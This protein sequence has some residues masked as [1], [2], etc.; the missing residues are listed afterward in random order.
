VV[1]ALETRLRPVTD[2]TERR[3]WGLGR[4]RDRASVIR[5]DIVETDP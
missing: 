3:A 2:D 4:R 5:G 1:L